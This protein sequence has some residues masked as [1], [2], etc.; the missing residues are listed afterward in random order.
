VFELVGQLFCR[1][2]AQRTTSWMEKKKLFQ[3]SF[4]DERRFGKIISGRVGR[5]GM[6]SKAFNIPFLTLKVRYPGI[7]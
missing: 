3:P 2:L 5:V 1:E 6:P 4:D 7:S